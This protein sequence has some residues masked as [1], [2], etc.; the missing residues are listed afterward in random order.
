MPSA[1]RGEESA[2]G[3]VRDAGSLP[4]CCPF[5]WYGCQ[6]G[7]SSPKDLEGY[8]LWFQSISLKIIGLGGGNMIGGSAF[9]PF[10]GAFTGVLPSNLITAV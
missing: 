10:S 8:L 1:E 9:L 6:K 7:A 3:R 5:S 4:A 2:A